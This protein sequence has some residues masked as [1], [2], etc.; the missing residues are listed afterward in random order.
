MADSK[1]D[2]KTILIMA[3]QFLLAIPHCK[4]LGMS[5]VSAD[6]SGIT[7]ELP[8][9]EQIVGNRDTGVIHSGV[10]TTLMDTSCGI[11]TVTALPAPEACPTLDLRIDHMTTPEPEKSLFA[12][13]EAYRVTR[14]IV[15]TRGTAWQD[16][17][18]QP[19]AHAVGTFMRL[20]TLLPGKMVGKKKKDNQHES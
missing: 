20:G 2:N 11:S 5:I 18:D 15:F 7:I 13:V 9:S 4:T 1:P 3:R 16:S 14:N 10:V 6:Q 8:W 19:I 17:P 12:T